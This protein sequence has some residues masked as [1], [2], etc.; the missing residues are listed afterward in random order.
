MLQQEILLMYDLT[1]LLYLCL[2]LASFLFENSY[3][4][5]G[6]LQRLSCVD[7]KSAPYAKHTASQTSWLHTRKDSK[8]CQSIFLEN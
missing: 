8:T 6:L 5:S 1:Q 4:G 3:H 2:V 7:V